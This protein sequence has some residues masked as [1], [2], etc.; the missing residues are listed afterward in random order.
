ME[1]TR[2][3]NDTNGNPRYVVAYSELLNAKDE[4]AAR[5]MAK[6]PGRIRFFVDYEYEIALNKAKKIGGKKFHNKQ[7][8]G[9]IVFQSYNTD[10]LIKA[11][12]EIKNT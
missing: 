9:G 2:I 10:Q 8:G 1:L 12:Q 6:L 4:T 11:I 5:E 3:N 7:Y